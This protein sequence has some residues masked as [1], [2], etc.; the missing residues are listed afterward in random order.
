MTGCRLMSGQKFVES[1]AA[2]GALSSIR[3]DPRPSSQ[4]CFR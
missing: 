1:F 3:S 4:V 2:E